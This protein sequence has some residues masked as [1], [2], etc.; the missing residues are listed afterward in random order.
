[1]ALPNL[2][3]DTTHVRAEFDGLS[4][5]TQIFIASLVGLGILLGL[6]LGALMGYGVAVEEVEGRDCIEHEDTLYCA[7]EPAAE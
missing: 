2:R 3:D 5:S 6:L 7:D 1:M 4:R